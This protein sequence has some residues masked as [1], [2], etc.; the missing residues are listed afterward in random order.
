MENK[1]KENGVTYV[2]KRVVDIPIT[3]VLAQNALSFLVFALGDQPTR[4]LGGEPDQS[5]LQDTGESLQ[6]G[7][8][9]PCPGATLDAESAERGPLRRKG[10]YVG[11]KGEGE[12]GR[13]R[14]HLQPRRWI[15]NTR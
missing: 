10:A 2:D 8:D 3:M 9:A 6:D 1:G 5:A 12:L 4:A 11:K 7:R 15:P 13:G 14:D